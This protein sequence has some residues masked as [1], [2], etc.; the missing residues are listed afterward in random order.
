MCIFAR[1]LPW[2]SVLRVWDMFFCEGVSS[3]GW[4]G[5]GFL[6][7]QGLAADPTVFGGLAFGPFASPEPE[8]P[9]SSLHCW[10][11]SRCGGTESLL[12]EL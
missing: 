10:F 7:S 5:P 2:A 6:T 9:G 4:G 11:G 8:A 3:M 12:T 1:T